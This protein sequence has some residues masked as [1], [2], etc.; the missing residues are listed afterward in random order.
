MNREEQKQLGVAKVRFL[1]PLLGL[2]VWDKHSSVYI[3]N[4]LNHDSILDEIK[5]YQ[6]NWIQHVNR[7]GNNR[8]P[9]LTLQYQ[10]N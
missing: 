2:I 10:P 1:R 6:Q 7:I 8:S 3:R 4:K 5:S 9:N